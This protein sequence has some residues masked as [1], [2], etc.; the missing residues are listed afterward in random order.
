MPYTKLVMKLVFIEP[1]ATT[2]DGAANLYLTFGEISGN[3]MRL[4]KRMKK[5]LQ[6]LGMREEVKLGRS[7]D[8]SSSTTH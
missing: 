6:L 8:T 2:H 4:R 7:K 1:K 5:F 3:G